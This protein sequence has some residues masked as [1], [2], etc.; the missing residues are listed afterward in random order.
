MYVSSVGSGLC[1]SVCVCV[2]KWF[3]ALGFCSILLSVCIFE[4]LSVFLCPWHML[5][6]DRLLVRLHLLIL[7]SVLCCVWACSVVSLVNKSLNI[8]GKHTTAHKCAHIH[9]YYQTL[10]NVTLPMTHGWKNCGILHSTLHSVWSKAP[11]G[12][13]IHTGQWAFRSILN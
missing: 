13:I 3:S 1:V 9:W 12:W 7:C 10:K 8:Q 4:F 2:S 11:K 6:N 5:G